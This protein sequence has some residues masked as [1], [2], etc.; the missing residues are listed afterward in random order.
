MKFKS[1][2]CLILS[3]LFV[4]GLTACKKSE[5][6][7]DGDD[8]YYYSSEETPSTESVD[9]GSS[10]ITQTNSGLNGSD[11]VSNSSTTSKTS[12]L[13]WES[14]TLGDPYNFTIKNSMDIDIKGVGYRPDGYKNYKITKI[15]ID[16]GETGTVA[17]SDTD[18]A[19]YESFDFVFIARDGREA[20]FGPIIVKNNRGLE[21]SYFRGG[22]SYEYI[23]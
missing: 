10:D 11:I 16:S 1:V 13:D 14:V 2:I 5:L 8:T 9:T 17:F 3:I 21:L 22:Y 4:L 6:T 15:E 12:T 19:N 7:I 20:E 23:R 18:L